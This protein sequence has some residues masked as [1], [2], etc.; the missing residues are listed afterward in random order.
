MPELVEDGKTG[1]L[2]D[3]FDASSL[4]EH[5]K[6]ILKNAELRQEWAKMPARLQQQP[7]HSMSKRAAIA[8][9]THADRA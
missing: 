5:L 3:P 8:I 1:F 7:L 6:T 4:C 9:S 2:A